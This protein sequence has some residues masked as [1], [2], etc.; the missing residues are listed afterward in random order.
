MADVLFVLHPR[1]DENHDGVVR[2]REVL[3]T[4][5]CAVETMARPQPSS[6][7]GIEGVRLVAT[8]G[9]DGTFIRAA[10][11][12]VEAGIPLLGVNLGRLGFLAW[13]DVED[14]ADALQKWVDGSTEI[15][16]RAT[17]RVQVGSDR[18]IAIN[19]AAVLKRVE[20]NVIKVDIRIGNEPAGSFHAD[21]ALVA[22]PT[23]STGYTLSAGGPLLD[24]RAEA[25][26][27]VPLNA[28]NIA[29]RPL[30]TPAGSAVA[31]RVDEPTRLVL[32]GSVTMDVDTDTDV[33]CTLDGPRMK[34]VRAPG[35][36]GFYEQLRDKM[37]WG[38]PLVR[39]G[40]R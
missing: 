35:A 38:K 17:M 1:V 4:A 28:H 3:Q 22:T 2:A 10:R 15:E 23:G 30:V 27:F 24:P 12:V 19:E 20:A 25:L 37:M 14:A 21:G 13:V 6:T 40:R 11:A 26:L 31:V 8:F 7:Q 9:G 39:E 33:S 36:A 32:D 18:A 5:G 16:T 34:L 29:T